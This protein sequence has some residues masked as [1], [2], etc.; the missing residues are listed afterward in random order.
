MK[1]SMDEIG[2][3]ELWGILEHK[4]CIDLKKDFSNKNVE[5]WICKHPTPKVK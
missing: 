2:L 1:N 5:A 3:T 4:F